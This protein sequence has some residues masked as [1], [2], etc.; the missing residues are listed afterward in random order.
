MLSIRNCC[1]RIAQ[2]IAILYSAYGAVLLYM[3]ASLLISFEFGKES[4]RL[5]LLSAILVIVFGGLFVGVGYAAIWRGSRLSL[6]ILSA[7]VGLTVFI[8]L[9]K[10]VDLVFPAMVEDEMPYASETFS[11]LV[12]TLA[13][14]AS[15]RAMFML[16]RMGYQDKGGGDNISKER[17][18]GPTERSGE[19]S[20]DTHLNIK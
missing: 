18:T 4:S 6:E 12:S 16:F 9:F 20:G 14:Y 1:K 7:L 3:G 5:L 11:L 15:Y 13:G 10:L 2:L 19:R 8:V 17:G